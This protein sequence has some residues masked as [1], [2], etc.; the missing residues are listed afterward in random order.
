MEYGIRKAMLAYYQIHFRIGL[1]NNGLKVTPQREFSSTNIPLKVLTVGYLTVFQGSTPQKASENVRNH[2]VSS[3]NETR[4]WTIA[5]I[6]RVRA[7]G[8][9][10]FG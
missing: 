2:E 1:Q 10:S 8:H 5:E 6:P 7:A 3:L 4:C 9:V